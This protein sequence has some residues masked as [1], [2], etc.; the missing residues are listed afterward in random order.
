MEIFRKDDHAIWG[1]IIYKEETDVR[2][3]IEN[4]GKAISKKQGNMNYPWT[5]TSNLNFI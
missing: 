4:V 5:E 2:I 3:Q 1:F